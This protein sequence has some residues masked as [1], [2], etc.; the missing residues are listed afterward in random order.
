MLIPAEMQCCHQN[1]SCIAWHEAVQDKPRSSVERQIIPAHIIC[2]DNPIAPVTMQTPSPKFWGEA[3]DQ[4]DA[5]ASHHS[6]KRA[7]IYR[8]KGIQHALNC[9]HVDLPV[10]CDLQIAHVANEI[11][12]IISLESSF[13]S[14]VHSQE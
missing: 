10:A 5:C 14:A 2:V 12:D 6:V 9:S 11:A 3:S 4:I 13:V 1:C 7:K 8:C